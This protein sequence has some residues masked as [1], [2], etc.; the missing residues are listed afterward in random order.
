[1]FYWNNLIQQDENEHRK[2]IHS[3]T[4]QQILGWLLFHPLFIKLALKQSGLTY[5]IYS[6]KQY[7]ELPMPLWC[8][9]KESCLE[10]A[11]LFFV[12]IIRERGH[13][14]QGLNCHFLFFATI[15]QPIT[16]AVHTIFRNLVLYVSPVNWWIKYIQNYTDFKSKSY[17]PI[18]Y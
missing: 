18:I 17:T 4:L 15:I 10:K 5:S 7:T 6:H 8:F 9:L 2:Q 12:Y 16:Y 3:S 1:M 14:F 13:N 11:S